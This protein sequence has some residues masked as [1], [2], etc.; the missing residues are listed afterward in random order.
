MRQIKVE[1]KDEVDSFSVCI[2]S[3]RFNQEITQELKRGALFRLEERGV[4][5]EDIS[6]IEV[7]GAIEIPLVAKRVAMSKQAAVIIALGAVIKGETKHFD[8]VCEQVSQGC[9]QVALAYDI[10]VIFGVLTTETLSQAWDRLGGNH[11]HKG[12]EVADCAIEMY[13]LLENL[14]NI[15]D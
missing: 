15:F 13:Y 10:P 3:S 12:I 11:G 9:Q 2:I 1:F 8:Y 7:P 6:V 14:K 5:D 4:K